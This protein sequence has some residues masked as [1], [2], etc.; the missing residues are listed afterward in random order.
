MSP[1]ELKVPLPSHFLL[2]Q[3]GLQCLSKIISSSSPLSGFLRRTML[4]RRT[5][6]L[7]LGLCVR[8]IV[9]SEMK[10]QGTGTHGALLWESEKSPG[11]KAELWGLHGR[12]LGL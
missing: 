9:V 4:E 11:G 3:P 7:F 1:S 2:Y 6:E 12:V 10:S 8:R 5:A